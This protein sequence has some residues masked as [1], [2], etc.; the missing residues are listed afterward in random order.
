M[1][2]VSWKSGAR[3]VFAYRCYRSRRQGATACPNRLPMRMADAD[4]AV[5][6]AVEKTLMS[7]TVV[8]RAL[9]LAE[10]EIVR[11][12]TARRRETARGRTR[13]SSKRRSGG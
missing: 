6:D 4:D 10:A 13:R 5:L 7:P 8:E 3:R 1:E 11:D 2:V 9:A 12:G